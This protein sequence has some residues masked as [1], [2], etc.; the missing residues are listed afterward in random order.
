MALV[1]ELVLKGALCGLGRLI[2]W[3]SFC[4]AKRYLKHCEAFKGPNLQSAHTGVQWVS[5]GALW[6]AERWIPGLA[7][8]LDSKKRL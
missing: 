4:N 3:I 5:A 6:E 1:S 7:V 2:R 8:R